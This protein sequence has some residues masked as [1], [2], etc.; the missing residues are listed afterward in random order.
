MALTSYFR[1]CSNSFG[2]LGMNGHI[3]KAR[4]WIEDIRLGHLA[5]FL[6][7]AER[8]GQGERYIR[9]LAPLAIVSPRIV[10]A[11][12][13]GTAPGHLTVTG[14]AKALPYSWAEQEKLLDWSDTNR[15]TR[16][17]RPL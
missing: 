5:S 11:I 12:A 2:Y 10:A 13:N 15:R 14:L 3:A 7:V 6:E 4:S 16:G 1:G 9:L 17:R 8:E